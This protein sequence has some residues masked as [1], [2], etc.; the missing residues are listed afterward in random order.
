MRLLEWL[1]EVRGDTLT[2]LLPKMEYFLFLSSSNSK[3]SIFY[4]KSYESNINR[5][6]VCDDYPVTKPGHI[7]EKSSPSKVVQG[8]VKEV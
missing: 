1:S 4:S 3:K 7:K 2:I 5:L 6:V 8:K